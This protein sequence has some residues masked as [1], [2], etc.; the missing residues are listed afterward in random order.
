MEERGCDEC[1]KK[2][3]PKN[4]YQLYCSKKCSGNHRSKKYHLNNREKCNKKHKIYR[5]K[6]PEKIKK[7]REDW[8]KKNLSYFKE[9]REKNK[10]IIRRKGFL[11]NQKRRVKVLNHYGNK[12]MECS[13]T[14]EEVLTIDHINN[15]GNIH[16]KEGGGKNLYQW[17][18]KNNFPEG[19]Q[20]LCYNCNCSKG[21]KR[22]MNG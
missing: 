3:I 2:F 13:E 22:R 8:N 7:Y 15:D 20:I 9:Y 6:N 19:F 16:R 12:C 18:I 1:G 21:R 10:E 11:R 17:L 14:R 4:K 5:E